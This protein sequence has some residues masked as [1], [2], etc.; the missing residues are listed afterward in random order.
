M[1]TIRMVAVD[2][3]ARLGHHW[4]V[5]MHSRK[6][7]ARYCS[8]RS[9]WDLGI[10]QFIFVRKQP[11]SPQPNGS[12]EE[13]VLP[14]CGPPMTQT[15][16]TGT[17]LSPGCMALWHRAHGWKH[18]WKK[19]TTSAVHRLLQRMI[20]SWSYYQ[21]WEWMV[22]CRLLWVSCWQSKTGCTFI[23]AADP[24][25]LSGPWMAIQ[26]CKLWRKKQE[27]CLIFA[28]FC[29][30]TSTWRPLFKEAPTLG[31]SFIS[32]LSTSILFEDFGIFQRQSCGKGIKHL[33]FTEMAAYF[34]MNDID[35]DIAPEIGGIGLSPNWIL[36]S[37]P[38][39]IIES[40]RKIHAPI[41]PHFTWK[42]ASE[43][44]SFLAHKIHG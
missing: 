2:S 17:T 8:P 29:E 25:K 27:G 38:S 14:L 41:A 21:S 19:L 32:K 3:T 31:L 4:L 13:Q 34:R 37:T 24:Y 15:C 43:F 33:S 28:R 16:S 12:A 7:W 35:I 6:H 39:F 10:G 18:V 1:K 22:T 9:W 36:Q 26:I 20:C 42:L 23:A 44:I 30:I 40:R 11:V 5:E